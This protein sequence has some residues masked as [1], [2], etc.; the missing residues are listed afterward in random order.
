MPIKS[1]RKVENR[2]ALKNKNGARRRQE[3]Y[4]V[5]DEKGH[6]HARC[7]CHLTEI[8]VTM[9]GT[10]LVDEGE[11]ASV[12][13]TTSDNVKVYATFEAMGL[14]EDLLRGIYAYGKHISLLHVCFLYLLYAYPLVVRL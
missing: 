14:N 9:A 7:A 13:F 4:V 2:V 6:A 12:E 3:A 10:R 5:V 11:D 8:C 1:N